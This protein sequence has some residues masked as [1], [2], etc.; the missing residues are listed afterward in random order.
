VLTR[1]VTVHAVLG[2]RFHY[3]AVDHSGDPHN[4][5]TKPTLPT[6]MQSSSTELEPKLGAPAPLMDEV[7]AKFGATVF[8]L[9]GLASRLTVKARIGI[10]Q[11]RTVTGSGA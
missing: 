6:P 9:A 5:H 8:L 10:A 2:M 1:C 11:V 4:A 7:Y 3:W